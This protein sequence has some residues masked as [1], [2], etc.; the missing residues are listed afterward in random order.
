MRIFNYVEDA[1]EK[2]RLCEKDARILLYELIT[3]D[4][5][6]LATFDTD[7]QGVCDSRQRFLI[8]KSKF[9]QRWPKCFD[10]NVIFLS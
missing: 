8:R 7:K 6:T 5:R 2:E 1:M 4:L 3:Y 10:L 9:G